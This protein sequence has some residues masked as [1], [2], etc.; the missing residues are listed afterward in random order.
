MKI[1]TDEQADLFRGVH[2]KTQRIVDAMQM[3][4]DRGEADAEI[5]FALA[6]ECDGIKG[7]LDKAFWWAKGH[8]TSI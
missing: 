7:D 2:R 4:V 5:L 6:R 8:V 3:M 1:V